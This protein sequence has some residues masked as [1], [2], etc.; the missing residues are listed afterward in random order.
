MNKT[1]SIRELRAL[2]QAGMKDCNDALVEANWD[3]E[4]AV[5][6]IKVKGQNI[7]SGRAG[8]VAS[9]GRVVIATSGNRASMVE[10][11]CQ[12]DFT[13]RSPAFIAFSEQAAAELSNSEGTFDSV[14]SSLEQTRNA[15]VSTTKE[16]VVVRRWFVEEAASPLAKVFSYTH[17]NNQIGVVLTLLASSAE[18]VVS[19]EFNELGNDLVMQI[20]AMSPLA[21]SVESLSP[22][23]TAK[24]TVIFETQLT[25]A[26]KPQAAWPKIMAGKLNKWHTE[27][28]L[29]NQ[30]S[31][32]VPKT[33]VAQVVANVGKVVGGDITVV[34]FIRCQVGE[35]IEKAPRENLQAAVAEAMYLQQNPG[36]VK[37]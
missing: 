8:R 9:E 1:E 30:E 23:E 24:Q 18:A 25:E 32:V 10:V 2:T 22:V 13:A 27:V 16:N 35:G 36:D 37:K 14:S 15:V 19:K 29:L 6:I 33:T 5:D 7:T 3:I 26:K 4:K 12:T 17:S 31:V 11:N 34:N 21:V 20:A 28:C